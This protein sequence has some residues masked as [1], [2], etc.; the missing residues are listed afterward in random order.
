MKRTW[1]RCTLSGCTR[2][3]AWLSAE[4]GA[5]SERCCRQRPINVVCMSESEA[6]EFKTLIC[7]VTHTHILYSTA[8]SSALYSGR[9]NKTASIVTR[10]FTP[11]LSSRINDDDIKAIGSKNMRWHPT[12]CHDDSG[13]VR[14]RR[15]GHKQDITQGRRN[16]KLLTAIQKQHTGTVTRHCLKRKGNVKK[17]RK[18]NCF[19]MQNSLTRKNN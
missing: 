6:K 15:E 19:S 17:K 5:P 18:K 4:A 1:A 9:K 14:S 7:K 13:P 10:V 2:F 16:R 12:L 8:S 11:D 3:S